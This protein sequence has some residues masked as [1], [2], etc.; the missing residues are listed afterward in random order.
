MSQYP[1]DLYEMTLGDE[2]GGDLK[3]VTHLMVDDLLRPTRE[4]HAAGSTL[5]GLTRRRMNE[6]VGS[7]PPSQINCQVCRNTHIV[8]RLFALEKLVHL[9]LHTQ[10]SDAD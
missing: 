2:V 9:T 5:C 10:L 4:E 7:G 1:N 8:R 6:A 3:V